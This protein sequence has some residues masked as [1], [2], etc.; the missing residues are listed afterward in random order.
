[1]DSVC[2][3]IINFSIAFAESGT[4]NVEFPPWFK[5]GASTAAYQ[6]EG[7]WNVSGK[8][9]DNHTLATH[10]IIYHLNVKF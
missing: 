4:I 2:I 8:L 5:F 3:F 1:M 6:I 9:I 10:K 7:A